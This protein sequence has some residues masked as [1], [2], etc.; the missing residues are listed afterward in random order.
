MTTPTEELFQAIANQAPD[1]QTQLAMLVGSYGE[2]TWDPYAQGSGGGGAFGF[3][4][5]NYP[6]A[7]ETATPSQQ[8]R[9]ILPAYQNAESQVPSTVTNPAAAAEYQALA[10]EKPRG[11]SKELAKIAATNQPTNYGASS[12]NVSNWSQVVKVAQAYPVGTATGPTGAPSG[13][14]ATSSGTT[15]L[16]NPL[17]LNL[18]PTWGPSWA[19][20]NWGA[21]A[22][23]A[24]IRALFPL[25]IA[26]VGIILIAWGLDMTFKGGNKISI[27]MPQGQGG[28][29]Q[30]QKPPP[31]GG[32]KKD[33]EKAGET[34]AVVAA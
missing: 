4:P 34:A 18:L 11:M 25:F 15:S 32:I 28:G 33:T 10:A 5:P 30:D 21:D 12:Y 22:G 20:W 3:T 16:T 23:N 14:P 2:S 6:A 24:M 19:P 13:T 8:V 9:A 31:Q 1:Q 27:Q 26:L 29:Q 7:D 17:N